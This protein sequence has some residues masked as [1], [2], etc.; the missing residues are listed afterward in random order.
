MFLF[1]HCSL[2]SQPTL[3]FDPRFTTGLKPH[4]RVVIAIQCPQDLDTAYLLALLHEEVG[5]AMR[6]LHQRPQYC[7]K[8]HLSWHYLR[9]LN[10]LVNYHHLL[11]SEG[12]HCHQR[13]SL[14]GKLARQ[15]LGLSR[16]M[17]NG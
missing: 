2:V 15:V 12:P 5:E 6:P 17:I 10:D 3:H 16:L 14:L 1:E 11:L 9:H 7:P 13:I 4:I 8:H